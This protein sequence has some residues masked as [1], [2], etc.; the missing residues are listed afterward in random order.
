MRVMEIPQFSPQIEILDLKNL[1]RTRL[2]Q[3]IVM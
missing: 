3:T 1:I 2:N